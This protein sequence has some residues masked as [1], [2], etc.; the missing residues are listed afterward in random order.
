VDE[1]A[2]I[3]V[4]LRGACAVRDSAIQQVQA[5]YD[6]PIEEKAARM[7]S[8]VALAGTYAKANRETIFG[9]K[10]RS[11]ATALATFGLRTG[12]D[13]LKP[14]KSKITWDSILEKLKALGQ[15]VRTVEEVDKQA[16]LDAKLTDAQYAEIGLRVDKAERFYVEAKSADAN[17]ISTDLEP[18]A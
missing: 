16:L 3:E 7:K 6:G 17:R 9:A 11:A 2:R 14:L 10:L 18:A 13:S 4:S 1:I 15:Y 5:Q 12:N 8:L